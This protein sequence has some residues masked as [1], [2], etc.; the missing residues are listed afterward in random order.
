VP[1]EGRLRIYSG[2]LGA[3]SLGLWPVFAITSCRFKPSNCIPQRADRPV[4]RH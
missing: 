1:A 4:G 2:P 3:S